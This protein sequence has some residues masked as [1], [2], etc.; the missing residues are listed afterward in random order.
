M[1]HP[2]GI[3]RDV[4][5]WLADSATP[6]V[7][8]WLD[9]MLAT[10]ARTPQ[11]PAWVFPGRWLPLTALT[12]VLAPIRPL[13]WRPIVA[14][15]LVAIL[16]I[17]ALAVYAGSQKRLP[18]PF[19]LARTGLVAYSQNGDIRTADLATGVSTPIV[20][21]ANND[22]GPR[23]SR[24]G[25]RFAFLR[26]EGG[27]YM[28]RLFVANADGSDVRSLTSQPF[29]TLAP[30]DYTTYAFSPDGQR[31][32]YVS[33]V[34]T[35]QVLTVVGMDGTAREIDTGNL[36]V[37]LADWRPPTG[38]EIL[39]MSESPTGRGVYAVSANGGPVRTTVAPSLE[40]NVADASWSPN[41]ST[42]IYTRWHQAGDEPGATIRTR[43][44]D[45]DGSGDRAV[46]DG[47]IGTFE[48]SPAWSSDGSRIALVRGLGLVGRTWDLVVHRLDGS[49]P[50]I[51]AGP[52]VACLPGTPVWLPDD[53]GVIAARG[54]PEAAV[55]AQVLD[56]KTGVLRPAPLE[57]DDPSVQRLAP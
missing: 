20:L 55:G 2:A 26:A 16:V 5:E 33:K 12:R 24:D 10:T 51:V 4:R 23:W 56:P 52:I 39:F 49:A 30:D 54:C 1:T 41:G 45:A 27:P 44:V 7:P 53:S 32:I 42:V 8:D 3:E 35:R 34:G 14:L 47:G 29:R 31:L 21:G 19:G 43:V 13:P 15:A 37:R 57:L 46:A 6:H 50:D 9:D 28:A 11:R 25:T 36:N 22:Y 40:Y 48:G 18:A 17:A 38:D